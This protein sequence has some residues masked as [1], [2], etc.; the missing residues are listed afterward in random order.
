MTCFVDTSAMYAVLDADDANHGPA[1]QQ[2][3]A[4]LKDGAILFTS[5]YVLV[6]TVALLQHRIGVECVRAFHQEVL[7]IVRIE[8]IDAGLHEAGVAGLLGAGRRRLSLVD[9]VSFALLRK[10]GV[11]EVFAFDAHFAEQG[12]RCLPAG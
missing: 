7:P 1:K 11:R 3:A 12:F 8:W 2:W 10:L 5:N 9:C 6:E 4:S